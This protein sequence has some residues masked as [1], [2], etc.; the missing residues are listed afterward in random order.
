M[1]RLELLFS[2]RD[3]KEYAAWDEALSELVQVPTT[4]GVCRAALT[5]MREMAGKGALHHRIPPS[6]YLIAAAAQERATVGV[7]H[8][9]DHFDR[10]TAVLNFESR[11]IAPR[12]SLP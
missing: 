12:G 10:L 8:Y 11:W 9:D 3:R 5:A 6:D 7:L 2:T 1:V 4:D